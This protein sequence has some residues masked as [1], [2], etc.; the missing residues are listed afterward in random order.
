M[1]SYD[2]FGR[3]QEVSFAPKTIVEEVVQN[4]RT[5]LSTVVWSVP[6]D[7]RFG[8]SASMLDSPLPEA[9]A[10]LSSE[11]YTAVKRYEPR[12]VIKKITFEG[13]LDGRLVP[14]VRIE[15]NE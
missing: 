9:M 8:I 2:V 10:A 15:I 5:I 6:L 11:I 7:R 12:C 3:A 13:D 4:V 1:D 14:K